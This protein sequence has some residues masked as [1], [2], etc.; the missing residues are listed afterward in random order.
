MAEVTKP[1][2][3]PKANKHKPMDSDEDDE[4]PQNE[5]GTSSNTQPTVPV[6]HF[7]QG[8]ATSSKDPSTRTNSTSSQKPSTST[9]SE[10][11]S[12]DDDD[13]HGEGESGPA[14]RSSRSHDSRRTV[15]YPDL[16][17][18]TNAGSFC[19]LTTENGEQQDVRNLTSFPCVQRSVCLDEL[20]KD[21]SSTQVEIPRG[22]DSQT[23]NMLERC[24]ATCGKA[25]G[26][27]A[28]R[29]SRSRKE[30][31]AQE[32]RGCYKQLAEAKQFGWNSW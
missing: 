31:S 27:R 26:A 19:F 21:S 23:R 20:T 9:S 5:P 14:K 16:W 4:V 29:K 32:V 15:F 7:Q 12:T 24:M 11:K 17:V 30:A 18:L 13:E 6:L 28:K 3:L 25:A 10:D 2:D 8:S 1:S 22:V